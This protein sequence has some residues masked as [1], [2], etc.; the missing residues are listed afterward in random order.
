MPSIR[1][2]LHSLLLLCSLIAASPATSVADPTT[3]RY[4]VALSDANVS[5]SVKV[6]GI[7][8]VSGRFEQV[9]GGLLFTGSCHTEA[10]AFSIRTASVNTKNRLRDEIIRGP[11]LLDSQ[12]HPVIVYN[13]TRIVSNAHGPVAIDGV[14]QL[15]G[16]SRPIR[17]LIEQDK[18][19]SN[20]LS[21]ASHYQAVANISHTDFKIPSPLPGTS[22][23]INIRV[24]LQ[25]RAADLRLAAT[26]TQEILP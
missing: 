26:N 1:H 5:F 8:S 23:T 15:N 4:S 22:D 18:G 7:F 10:I 13:S 6:L 11:A 17:F 20:Q 2:R 9:Q 16:I 25:I 3:V 19:D 14:L 24:A 12:R 21:P